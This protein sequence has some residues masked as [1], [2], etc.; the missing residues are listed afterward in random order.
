MKKI[1]IFL[2]LLLFANN[3][4]SDEIKLFLAK[5]WDGTLCYINDKGE[6]V[7]EGEITEA[8]D[9]SE[10]LAKVKI[11]N[12]YVFIDQTGKVVIKSP[13][14]DTKGKIHFR[15]MGSF[16]DGLALCEL[17]NYEMNIGGEG[18]I[19]KKGNPVITEY[20]DFTKSTS[21]YHFSDF[22]EGFAVISHKG[23][24]GYINTK[25][26]VIFPLKLK[27]A[28][29]FSNGMAKV[30]YP[31]KD[32]YGYIDSTGK[33]A[34]K[35]RFTYGKEFSEGIA[36]VQE[37]TNDVKRNV[38]VDKAGNV[39]SILPNN[40][41][42]SSSSKF[43]NGIAK[44][45]LYVN[46]CYPEM[47]SRII[48]K[49]GDTIKQFERG[50]IISDFSEGYAFAYS[51]GFIGIVNSKGEYTYENFEK[52]LLYFPDPAYYPR[53]VIDIK[54]KSGFKNGLAKIKKNHMLGYIDYTG[55][56]I[57]LEN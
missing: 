13:E 49:N 20:A 1:M 51:E 6:V 47:A 23:E 17:N 27:K 28:F 54:P 9:F 14:E 22:N 15:I 52:K 41:K 19:D 25:G 39:V 46:D 57:Y 38:I 12:E 30:L 7:I 56:I 29:P 37:F 31:N 32:L 5:N 26:E 11:D 48:S 16:H 40:I 35:P 8:E 4:Y 50:T 34:I 43:N 53:P 42:L 36:I 33:I 24:Y 2:S 3:I 21:K 10:G 18:F 45:D 44:I 55:N